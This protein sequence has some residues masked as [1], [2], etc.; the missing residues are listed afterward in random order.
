MTSRSVA[1]AHWRSSRTRSRGRTTACREEQVD[2]PID[3]LG[4]V[5]DG[6]GKGLSARR[7]VGEAVQPNPERGARRAG[8]VVT[9]LHRHRRRADPSRASANWAEC[10]PAAPP[11]AATE[12][13]VGGAATRR[14]HRQP[15]LTHARRA[16]PRSSLA[17]VE[18]SGRRRAVTS[19]SSSRVLPMKLV[20]SA[21]RRLGVARRSTRAGSSTSVS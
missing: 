16:G 6:R 21:T 9:L 13:D 7:E 5:L 4:R 1:D 11:A 14:L 10:P 12:H 20:F 19:R 17:G 18:A 15:R 2:H 8:V 3:E